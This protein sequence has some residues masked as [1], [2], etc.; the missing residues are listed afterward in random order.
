MK[1]FLFSYDTGPGFHQELDFIEVNDKIQSQQH[2]YFFVD[3]CTQ[4][5]NLTQIYRY[6]LYPLLMYFLA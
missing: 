1:A 5:L 4:M 3:S 2:V 6:T